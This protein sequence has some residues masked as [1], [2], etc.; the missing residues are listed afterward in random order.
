MSGHY[1]LKG[2]LRM[3]GRKLTVAALI[4]AIRS[5]KVFLIAQGR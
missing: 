2:E 5:C 4:K 3:P 1:N